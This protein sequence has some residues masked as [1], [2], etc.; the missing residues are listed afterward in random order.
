M[1]FFQIHL[2]PEPQIT[3]Y[4]DLRL[5]FFSFVTAVFA[6]YI[7]LSIA[8][9]LKTTS[10]RM[11]YCSWLFGGALVMGL[12]I[13]TMHF[14]GMEAFTSHV[15][16]Q[17]DPSITLLSLLIAIVASGF[18]LFWVSRAR[19]TTSSILMG[20]ALM[21]IAI[22]SMHY[23]GMAAMLGMHISYLPSL[24]SLSIVIAILASQAALWLMVKNYKSET[25]FSFR[26]N[27]LSAIVMGFAI[28][29]MHYVGMAAAVMISSN[30]ENPLSEQSIQGGLPLFYIGIATSFIMFIFLIMSSSNQKTLISLKKTNDM[31]I[32]KETELIEA[33]QRA[34]QA[35]LAKS[36]FL[37]NM[38][39][40]IRTPLNVI[41]GMISL[42]ERSNLDEKTKKYVNRMAIS[43]KILLD[44]LVNILDL[45]KIEAEKLTLTLTSCD[46]IDLTKEIIDV[47]TPR[48]GEKKLKLIIDY[49]VTHSLKIISDPIRIQQVMTNLIDNAIKFTDKGFIK[50]RITSKKVNHVHLLIRFEVEDSGI[51]IHEEHFSRTFQKFSQVDDTSTRKFG[52]S[53]LGLVIS[54]ELTELLGGKIGFTSQ[55]GVGSTFWFEIPFLINKVED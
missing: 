10:G 1:N 15:Q 51:G 27:G 8:A 4:Y 14:I 45:S 31:L 46:F 34:E 39:H 35:N 13:W 23:V 42:L 19:V 2:I 33:R 21:G 54:K 32:A 29:G 49:D 38:S 22:V 48:I 24:F 25:A 3:G 26:L 52:G 9:R 36:F 43:S 12:G 20:G 55:L 5:V 6:S 37:A 53:G 47:M 41:I 7:A 17:Y 44:L 11:N 28:C 40:E 18:A 50:I 16:I 30:D